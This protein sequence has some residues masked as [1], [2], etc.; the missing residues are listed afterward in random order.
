MTETE[1]R[2]LSSSDAKDGEH[3][4]SNYS[5][6]DQD[7]FEDEAARMSCMS[8]GVS[9]GWGL[10]RPPRA[11]DKIGRTPSRSPIQNEAGQYGNVV[12]KPRPFKIHDQ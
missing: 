1:Q 2:G 4:R 8:N 6:I 7:M 12:A 11:I 9:F 3:Q 10:V 5:N